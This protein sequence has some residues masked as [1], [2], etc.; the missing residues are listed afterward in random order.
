MSLN[1]DT[2][3]T[4]RATLSE[5][6]TDGQKNVYFRY[7]VSSK[8]LTANLIESIITDAV[9]TNSPSIGEE[10]SQTFSAW[11]QQQPI[12]FLNLN[13]DRWLLVFSSS[14]KSALQN[15]LLSLDSRYGWLIESWIPDEILTQVYQEY[16][17]EDKSVNIERRWDPYWI[18][19]RGSDIPQELQDYY[20][21][22]IDE[23]VEKEIKF[24]LQTPKALVDDA[25][26]AG[27]KDHLLNKSELSETRFEMRIPKSD[28]MVS[29]GGILADTSLSEDQ[30]NRARVK[31]ELNGEIVHN[32]GD[33]EAVFFLLNEIERR[34]NIYDELDNITG[35]RDYEEFENGMARLKSY[36]PPKVL[37]VSFTAK[38]YNEEASI[39]LSNLLT[40]GQDDVELHGLI[41]DRNRLDFISETYTV[42]DNGEC[43]ILF[44][45]SNDSPTLYIRPT[46][47]T[48]AGLVYIYWK[49]KQKFDP[50]INKE[51]QDG[52]PEVS[53]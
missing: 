52:F 12:Y 38:D 34:N 15:H 9:D 14:L 45:E 17:P 26:Q 25:L 3:D 33:P 35:D 13:E 36:S 46:S 7:Y 1:Q 6:L 30:Y 50:R 47:T 29:D 42:F 43:D 23:F 11:Y 32:S 37:K 28:L 44:T 19:Q 16:C 20:E 41:K 27:V 18:Y 24:N 48:T 40:V 8:D 53:W 49:L 39:K 51:I 5:E 10:N 22:H 4:I 21:N 2:R 31:V